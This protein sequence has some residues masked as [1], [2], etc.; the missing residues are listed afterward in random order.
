MTLRF[1]WQG[2]LDESTEHHTLSFY[3]MLLD[4]GLDCMW[5]DF[6]WWFIFSLSLYTHAHA[7]WW[8]EYTAC[9]D[10]ATSTNGND[11]EI[12]RQFIRIAVWLKKS[13]SVVCVWCVCKSMKKY[14]LVVLNK[15]NSC[16]YMYWYVCLINDTYRLKTPSVI[17]QKNNEQ[18]KM[19]FLSYLSYY[20]F[21]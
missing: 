11:A 9:I 19:N 5:W 2:A 8:L 17:Q 15:K 18:F 12:E 20:F 7:K 13:W 10:W 6:L 21:V 4:Y 3:M 16:W 1:W 14:I